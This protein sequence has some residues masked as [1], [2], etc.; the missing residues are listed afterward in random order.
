M[1]ALLVDKG[2]DANYIADAANKAGAVIN[3]IVQEVKL[4]G[5][6]ILSLIKI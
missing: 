2:Y 3:S 4:K 6:T 5:T 1:K